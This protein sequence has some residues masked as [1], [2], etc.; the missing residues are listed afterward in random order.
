MTNEGLSNF[1]LKRARDNHFHDFVR[2]AV[3]FL[4]PAIAVHT[5]D[6]VFIHKAVAAVELQ[7]AVNDF[8]FLIRDPI[9]RHRRRDR[10]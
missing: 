9:F 8:A 7:A 4:H 5:S 3:D 1:A 2:A 10:I 6:A